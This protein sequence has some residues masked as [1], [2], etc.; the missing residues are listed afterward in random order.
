M[1]W[2][3]VVPGAGTVLLTGGWAARRNLPAPAASE[4]QAEAQ[5][6]GWRLGEPAEVSGGIR[7]AGL[8]AEFNERRIQRALR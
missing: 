8:Y 1:A 3:G 5:A 4:F 7:R 2:V 6:A